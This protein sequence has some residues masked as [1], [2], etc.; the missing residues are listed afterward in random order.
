M[1]SNW[2]P[3]HC[4]SE[5]K[6]V[7]PPW[8]TERRLLSYRITTWPSHSSSSIHPK[9]LKVVTWTYVFTKYKGLVIFYYTWNGSLQYKRDYFVSCIFHH[10]K[11]NNW[12]NRGLK[13]RPTALCHCEVLTDWHTH[14][15]AASESQT[16]GPGQGYLEPEPEPS[17]CL[18]PAPHWCYCHMM[19]L[20]PGPL[21]F[22]VT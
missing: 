17:R 12:R 16:K 8:K 10:N 7:Q 9:E 14:E 22:P 2:T 15:P 11:K 21:A 3:V 1:W 6:K 13:I 4:W 18:W 5:W 20:E 19:V